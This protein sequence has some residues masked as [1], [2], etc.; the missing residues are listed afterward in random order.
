VCQRLGLLGR[1]AEVGEQAPERSEV[2]QEGDD[3]QLRSAVRAE[4]RIDLV[5][6]AD[7][8]PVLSGM[9]RD[10]QYDWG[11]SQARRRWRL[12]ASPLS[13]AAEDATLAA[14]E[15]RSR[16]PRAALL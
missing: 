4:Q 10:P 15:E 11:H 8:S 9:S 3:A 5:D 13:R 7:L 12:P 6:L 14:L 2:D 16:R 1:E